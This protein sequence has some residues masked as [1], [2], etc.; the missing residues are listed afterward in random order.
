MGKLLPSHFCTIELPHV[1]E[2]FYRAREG[3]KA[4]EY[5]L[6][7]E[8]LTVAADVNDTICVTHCVLNSALKNDPY[9]LNSIGFRPGHCVRLLAF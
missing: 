8:S 2:F 4:P 5:E 9:L 3:W 6:N 1:I 7:P